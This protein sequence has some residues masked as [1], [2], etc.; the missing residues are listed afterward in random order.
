M[1]S[2]QDSERLRQRIAD[3]RATLATYLQ[4]EALAGLAHVRPEV[5]AGISYAR[6]EIAKLK[7]FLRSQGL[8]VAEQIR[9]FFSR[10]DAKFLA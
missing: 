3:H 8:S 10:K 2:E 4:H 9:Q 5:R 6:R 7:G 1:P